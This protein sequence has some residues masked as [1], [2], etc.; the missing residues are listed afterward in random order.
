MTT[1]LI[2]STD[3]EFEAWAMRALGIGKSAA[4]ETTR[5]EIAALP[6]TRN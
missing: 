3:A 2:L 1:F 5:R 6:E 4:F